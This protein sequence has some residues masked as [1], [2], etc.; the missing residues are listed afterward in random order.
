MDI[1]GKAR[2][3][4]ERRQ[5]RSQLAGAPLLV[6]QLG[7]LEFRNRM[8]RGDNSAAK[9]LRL[10]TVITVAEFLKLLGQMSPL[11]VLQLCFGHESFDFPIHL[12]QHADDLDFVQDTLT[13]TGA[14]SELNPILNGVLAGF[15]R[16]KR[17]NRFKFGQY[18]L[19]LDRLRYAT[20]TSENDSDKLATEVTAGKVSRVKRTIAGNRNRG[21][22]TPWCRFFQRPTGCRRQTC[23]FVHKCVICAS[24]EH[25]ATGCSV[26]RS[27]MVQQH[28]PNIL[29]TIPPERPPNPRHR[30]GRA[31]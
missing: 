20:T 2:T 19:E 14:S 24:P 26:R 23:N 28:A 30:R 1:G 15:N 27:S 7:A 10:G 17:Y 11:A 18:N 5:A 21:T 22:S 3:L 8:V 9:N 6:A 31:G 16:R 29:A 4:R 25:G 13:A 12:L